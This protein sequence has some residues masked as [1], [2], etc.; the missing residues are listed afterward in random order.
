MSIKILYILFILLIVCSCND[1]DEQIDKNCVENKQMD[2]WITESFKSNY[3]IQFPSNYE[4]QGMVGFEGN[5]FSK[6]RSDSLVELSYI[7]CSPLYCEDFSSLKTFSL[8][9]CFK[10]SKSLLSS[11]ILYS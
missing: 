3:S 1:N 7:Y 10:F 2:N 5:M 9:E 6:I 11:S 8:N 4:G